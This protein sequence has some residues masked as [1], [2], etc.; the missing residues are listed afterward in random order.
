MKGGKTVEAFGDNG[1]NGEK[2]LGFDQNGTIATPKPIPA[3]PLDPNEQITHFVSKNDNNDDNMISVEAEE[4]VN[5]S[6][7]RSKRYFAWGEDIISHSI[8]TT[9]VAVTAH[10]TINYVSTTNGSYFD[11]FE[12]HAG[13]Y[14]FYTFGNPAKDKI[15]NVPHKF[16]P[17]SSKVFMFKTQI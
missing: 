15:P 5:G 1:S 2:F 16:I 3:L 11:V 17:Y 10:N 8:G 12:Q 7:K 9:P 6:Q 4:P 13:M 14:D